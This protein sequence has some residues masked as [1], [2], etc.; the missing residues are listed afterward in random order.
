[1]ISLLSQANDFCEKILLYPISQRAD[2]LRIVSGYATH[3]MASWHIA[4]I[5]ERFG[6]AVDIDLIVGMC[7]LD[8]LSRSVHEG[9]K[10]IMRN[11]HTTAQSRL[12]CKYVVEGKPV[13]TKLYL[14]EKN[15]NP[16]CAYMGSANY[17][18]P[19]FLGLRREAMEECNPS[20]ARDYFEI[21]ESDTMYCNHAE[22]EDKV[23]I[24]RTHPILETEEA[25]AISLHGAGIQNVTLSLLARGG[26]TGRRSG[27]NWGQRDGREPNQAYIPLPASVARSGFFP[28]NRRQFSVLTDDG[29]QLILRVEQQ[30]DKAITTPLNNSQIGEYFRRRIGVANGAFISRIDLENYGRT[31]VAF[32]KLDEEQFFMD[33]SV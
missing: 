21:L 18:Q 11:Q 14:W 6:T 8:G 31:N 2:H 9:F 27:L 33:F 30:N 3:T 5:K 13:H 32:Y 26:E 25:P 24:T 4:E 29:I 12:T 22:V 15:G 19:A 7:G 17:T 20:I 10:E 1:M 28:L 16:F 23:I